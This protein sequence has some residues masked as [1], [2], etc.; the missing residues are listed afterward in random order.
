[1]DARYRPGG[2]GGFGPA[3]YPPG[4]G[5]MK[6]RATKREG[7]VTGAAWLAAAMLAGRGLG[8]VYRPIMTHLFAP[9]DGQGGAVGIALAQIPLNYYQTLLAIT[10]TG[11]N[12]AISRMVAER[13]VAGDGAGA[14]RVFRVSVWML[15]V[16]GLI[17]TIGMALSADWLARLS[18]SPEAAPGFI[19]TAPAVLL[20][21]MTGSWRGLFQGLQRMSVSATSQMLEAV[22]RVVAGLYLVWRWAPIGVSRGAMG[23]NLADMVGAVASLGFLLWAYWQSQNLFDT[24]AGQAAAPERAGA[25]AKRILVLS[26]PI[27]LVN[28]MLPVFNLIDGTLVIKGLMALGL[29]VTSAQAQFGHITQA[30]NLVNLP[31][32]LATALYASLIPA[33]AHALARGDREGARAKVA[34][35]YRLTMLTGFP[36]AAGLWILS[37]PIYRLVF[38]V[39]DGGRVLHALAWAA[40]FNMIHLIATA[41]LQGSGNEAVPL[42]SAVA[43]VAVKAVSTPLLVTHL[44]IDGAAYASVLAFGA[45]AVVGVV[46]GWRGGLF[47]P[48]VVD[49]VVRPGAAAA[50]MTVVCYLV[51]GALWSHLGNAIATLVAIAAGGV[52]YTLVLAAVGGVGRADLGRLPIF[53]PRFVRRQQ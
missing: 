9:Y 53:G 44:G 19:A 1:M 21:S 26:L 24:P 52:V 42:W 6:E 49:L 48:S 28:M 45:A 5:A 29:K 17:S 2:G 20:L 37:T 40:L 18:G 22:L 13:M 33:V 12:V 25:L 30:Y 32:I 3:R 35:S 4:G 51:Y 50:V 41:V 11:I 36:A 7:L 43:G 14:R 10:A 34:L 23:A 38:G 47:R 15:A 8:A 46:A 39:G 31:P 16:F 27:A